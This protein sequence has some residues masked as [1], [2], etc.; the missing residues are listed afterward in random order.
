[1]AERRRLRELLA[2]GDGAAAAD[3]AVVRANGVD[4]LTQ[5]AAQRGL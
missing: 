4:V 1:M 2:P 3:A 5:P